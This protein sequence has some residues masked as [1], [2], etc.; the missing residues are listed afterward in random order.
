MG[1]GTAGLIDIVGECPIERV[2]GRMPRVAANCRLDLEYPPARLLH[3]GQVGSI[4]LIVGQVK[5]KDVNEFFVLMDAGDV[6]RNSRFPKEV[7]DVNVKITNFGNRL[8]ELR[9]G[10]R[11]WPLATRVGLVPK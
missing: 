6:F 2:E 10:A 1:P 8:Q 11:P 5:F 9:Q 3:A 4:A 7:G